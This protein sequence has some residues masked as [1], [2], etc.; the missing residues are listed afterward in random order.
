VT[1]D[2]VKGD[3]S[4]GDKQEIT[5]EARGTISLTNGA[6]VTA[7][8]GGSGKTAG[9]IEMLSTEGGLTCDAASVV[10]ASSDFGGNIK[11]RSFENLTYN[12]TIRAQGNGSSGMGGT[13]FLQSFNA[14]VAG[15]G[16]VLATGKTNGTITLKA[17]TT[18]NTA[19][20]TFNPAP[21]TFPGM[22]EAAP[23]SGVKFNAPIPPC[24]GGC[25][26]ITKFTPS[27]GLVAGGTLVTI[28]GSGLTG[29]TEV[30]FSTSCDPLSGTAG[31]IV[32]PKTDTTLKV[33]SPA[34]PAGSYHII[35]IGPTGSF[36]T[37]DL[38]TTP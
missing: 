4:L 27:N 34:L 25:I 26:C 15:T 9:K 8:T 23:T 10:D 14:G 24:V 18:T 20:A 7:N 21:L 17:A 29:T 31:T 19:G 16:T 12:C 6:L 30:R 3:K 37:I 13:I 32:P 2:S 5:I 38:F 1:A 36:C 35:G 28:N 33:T 11:M 22:P